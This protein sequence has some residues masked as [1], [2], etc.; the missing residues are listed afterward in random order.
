MILIKNAD[1]YAPR[2]LG[3]C[4]L[5]L[6]GGKILA[7][8]KQLALTGL[9]AEILDAAGRI[10]TPGLIDQHVHITGAGGQC[11]FH[12]MTPPIELGTLVACGTTTVLGLLGTDGVTRDLHT[13]YA[14]ACA[15]EEEGIS[16]RIL[17]GSFAFPPVTFTGSV[18]EDMLFIDKVIGCKTA[19]AD[20][21]SSHPSDRELLRVLTDIHVGGML[22]GKQGIL[23]VHLGAQE[24]GMEQ[25]LTLAERDHV[26]IR[27]ISPTHVG[28]TRDLFEQ[29]LRFAKTGGMIDFSTGGTRFDEPCRQILLARES[30][31]PIE[32]M[33]LSSDGNAGVVIRGAD[34]SVTGYRKAPVDGNLAQVV[35]LIRDLGADISDAL[36]LVT[37]NPAENLSLRD[38][39]RIAP[40]ADA[41]LCL[42]DD[43]MNLQ[44]VIAR[45]TLLM[46]EGKIIRKG[47]FEA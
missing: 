19:I 42:F 36:R 44:E 3:I 30:G 33:T 40:G 11:G 34:G 6:G 27:R 8:E 22:S 37:S 41:D 15:L 7:I 5:L 13:L 39:G 23:H 28:R 38:K 1:V 24:E 46:H 32:N 4:D 2:H 17:T 14:K 21:R 16:A 35:K 25:L 43:R 45:G 29:A 12:S 20:A 47:T 10:L 18:R 26:P 9:A 31:V